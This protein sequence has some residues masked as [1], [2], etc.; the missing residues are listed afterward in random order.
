MKTMM[1]MKN[2]MMVIMIMA[3]MITTKQNNIPKKQ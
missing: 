3:M 1:R 2:L